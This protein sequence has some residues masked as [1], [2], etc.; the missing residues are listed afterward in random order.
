MFIN[1]YS[2]VQR[3]SIGTMS[4]DETEYDQQN[5][6]LWSFMQSRAGAIGCE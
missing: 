3:W 2:I 5:P 6:A 1:E 4:T